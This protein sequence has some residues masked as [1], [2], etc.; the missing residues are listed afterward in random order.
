MYN[1]HGGRKDW[2]LVIPS[3]VVMFTQTKKYFFK[4]VC[5]D[6]FVSNVMGKALDVDFQGLDVAETMLCVHQTYFFFLLGI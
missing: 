1:L 6:Q 3:N 5:F 4:M 2:G